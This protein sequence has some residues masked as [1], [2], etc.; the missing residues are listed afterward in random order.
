MHSFP[1]FNIEILFN[2]FD[3]MN[4]W[5]YL[6]IFLL[7]NDTISSSIAQVMTIFYALPNHLLERISLEFASFCR[8]ASY[9]RKFFSFQ[10]TTSNMLKFTLFSTFSSN[11]LILHFVNYIYPFIFFF[12]SFFNQKTTNLPLQIGLNN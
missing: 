8:G 6:R 11:L 4:L 10:Y 1:Y 2:W 5:I 3:N 9:F 7:L 12:F